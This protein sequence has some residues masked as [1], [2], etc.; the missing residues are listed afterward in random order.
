MW[1]RID[2]VHKPFKDRRI[3]VVEDEFLIAT[4]VEDLLL[5]WGAKVVGPFGRL[6]P[7]LAA[8]HREAIDGAVLDVWIDGETIERVAAVLV[9]RKLPVLLTTGYESEQLPPDLRHLPRLQKPF[10]KRDLR[11]MLEQAYR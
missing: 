6:E 8:A 10:D 7:A 3:L 11:R 1:A 5:G 2:A 4:E 9:L